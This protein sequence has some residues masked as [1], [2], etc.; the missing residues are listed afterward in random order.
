MARIPKRLDRTLALRQMPN[1]DW[2]RPAAEGFTEEQKRDSVWGRYLA[3]GQ[4]LA[5]PWMD[6]SDFEL[7]PE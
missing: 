3:P 6:P 1:G 5:M 7:L 4:N 2:C